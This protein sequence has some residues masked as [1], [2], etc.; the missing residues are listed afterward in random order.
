MSLG[1]VLG[2]GQGYCGVGLELKT[3]VKLGRTWAAETEET[4]WW[5]GFK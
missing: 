3:E 4:V 5:Q 2:G 1:H